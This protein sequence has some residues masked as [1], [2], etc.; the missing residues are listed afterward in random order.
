ME[1]NR[2]CLIRT[3]RRAGIKSLSADCHH[4]LTE[5]IEK[6]VRAVLQT[7]LLYNEERGTKILL[8]QDIHEAIKYLDTNL[9]NS[10]LVET[11]TIGK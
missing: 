4:I 5:L 10:E 3:A 8:K 6:R 11:K 2:P 1:I 9:T 7:A